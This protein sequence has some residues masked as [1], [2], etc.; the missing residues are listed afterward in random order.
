MGLNL[1]LVFESSKS[2]SDSELDL[3]EFSEYTT[4]MNLDT[5][6][7]MNTQGPSLGCLLKFDSRKCEKRS[8]LYSFYSPDIDVKL[9]HTF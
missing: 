1:I 2:E 8:Q 7:D 3:L 5:L 9:L 4:Y 6:H